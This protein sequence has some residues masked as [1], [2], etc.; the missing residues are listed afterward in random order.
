[1]Q[2]LAARRKV[3]TLGGDA[4]VVVDVVLPAVLGLV[5]VRE[6]GVEAWSVSW[7]A[8]SNSSRGHGELD[9]SCWEL[10]GTSVGGVP[11]V[12]LVSVLSL[13]GGQGGAHQ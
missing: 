7:A 5:L 13:T 10:C 11:A 8:V 6:A 3:L 2:Y 9:E 4:L 12:P 1:M